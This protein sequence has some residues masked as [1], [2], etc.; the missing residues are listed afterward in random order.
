VDGQ[1]GV[2]LHHLIANFSNVSSLS[3]VSAGGNKKAWIKQRLE[4]HFRGLIF[5]VI[6]LVM[7]H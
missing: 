6:L 2:L 7:A 1:A 4:F 3:G 5:P